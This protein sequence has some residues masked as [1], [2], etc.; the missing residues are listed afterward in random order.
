[1]SVKL[2]MRK[3]P[4]GNISYTLDINHNGQRHRESIGAKILKATKS[5]DKKE[6]KRIAE[7]IRN[8]REKELIIEGYEIKDFRKGDTCFTTYFK[9]YSENYKKGDKRKVTATFGKFNEYFGRIKAKQLNHTKC[10]G[11]LEFLQSHE[12][13]NSNDTIRSYFGV[14]RKIIH[15]AERDEILKNDPTKFIKVKKVY[16]ELKKQ[17]LSIDEITQ[18]VNTECGNETVKRAFLF[19][20]LTG[21]GM[22]ELRAL[23]WSSIDLNKKQLSHFNRSKTTTPLAI[24][25]NEDAISFIGQRRNISDLVF[26]DLPSSNGANK[27]LRNWIKRANIDKHVTWY[28]ARHTFACNLLI[29]GANQKTV[30]NLMGHVSSTMID[31]YLN[32]VDELNEKAVN[33]IPSVRKKIG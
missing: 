31:K 1:M 17:I 11:F 15:N 10:K 22:A 32:Y 18:L 25:L 2:R 33:A 8:Q 29:H 12:G 19:C 13:I 21:L 4:S 30:S 26:P 20:T 24:P 3:L 14:F 28:C 27:T 7:M 9:N 16:G 23:K 6:I 5:T